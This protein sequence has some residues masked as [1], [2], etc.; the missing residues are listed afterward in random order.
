MQ[1][2]I[3]KR[4]L[5]TFLRV[6]SLGSRF[7]LIIILA[8]LLTP[9]EVGLYGLVTVSIALGVLLLGG[10]FYTYSHREFLSQDKSKRFSII[11]HHI[12]ANLM[13]Y[14]IFLPLHILI[15]YY[16]FLP[17]SLALIFFALL[18]VEHISQE[19]YRLLNVMHEQIKASIVIFIRA[20][21]WIFVYLPLMVFFPEFNNL[22][23]ILIA[24][25]I[26]SAVSIIYGV[27]ILAQI[28]EPVR[29]ARFNWE[30]IKKGFKISLYYIIGTAC[31][32]IITS[33]DRYLFEFL[34]GTELLAVY[35]LFI[36][37]ALSIIAFLEPAVFSF[38]YPRLVESWRKGKIS[39]YKKTMKEL[40]I[41]TLIVALS[42]ALFVFICTPYLLIWID[43]DIY[44]NNQS[45]LLILLGASVMSSLSMIPHYGL[46]AK[47]KDKIIL[48]AHV[49][50]LVVFLIVALLTYRTWPFFSV[51]IALLSSFSW[52]FM[53]KT[54]FYLNVKNE[55][56]IS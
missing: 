23:G 21:L 4:L 47:S 17:W 18:V 20:S 24:W 34:S 35:V 39:E 42:L 5:N 8:K 26:G 9:Y 40:T 38:L 25:L 31:Y 12:I 22:N 49:S 29:W 48:F 1:N 6:L 45:L 30:W 19:I 36:S 37:L 32:R 43:N 33:L 16:K 53:C 27:N 41:V 7:L 51:A 28:L 11:Q 13:L 15:F 50:A 56:S 52:L 44:M 10:D 46:Y 3:K 54:F 55:I 2:E 14:S